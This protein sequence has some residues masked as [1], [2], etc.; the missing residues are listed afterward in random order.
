ML[1]RN[2]RR[3]YQST[4]IAQQTSHFVLIIKTEISKTVRWVHC[5]WSIALAIISMEMM[6]ILFFSVT[7]LITKLFTLSFSLSSHHLDVCRTTEALRSTVSHLHTSAGCSMDWRIRTRAAPKQPQQINRRTRAYLVT[8]SNGSRTPSATVE[9][10]FEAFSLWTFST[11]HK[12]RKDLKNMKVF[13]LC[14][15]VS[16][17]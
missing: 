2:T 14:P 9:C 17:N 11:S 4:E 6:M 15:Y 7:W 12:G 13:D 5:A 8:L 3:L 16:Q 1:M 10:S